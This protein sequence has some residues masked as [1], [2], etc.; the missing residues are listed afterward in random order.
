VALFHS[1]SITDFFFTNSKNTKNSFSKRTDQFFAMRTIFSSTERSEPE[2]S[3]T[4]EIAGESGMAVR[5][6][7]NL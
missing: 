5:A 2:V 1:I 7:G 4:G 3:L 6:V